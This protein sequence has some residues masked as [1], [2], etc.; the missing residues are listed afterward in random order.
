MEGQLATRG[1]TVLALIALLAA[2]APA[3]AADEGFA[4]SDFPP[5]SLDQEPAA[6][7]APKEAPAKPWRTFELITG[8]TYTSVTSTLTVGRGGGGA[9]LAIDAEGV[10]G[11]NREMWSPEIWTAYRF[12]ERHRIC[13]GF[14]DMTRTSTRALER[15]ITVDGVT[16]NV[17]TSVHS[18][19]GIQFYNLT[20]AWSFLQD[21]RMEMALTLGFDT[22]RAHFSVDASGSQVSAN[23]RFIFPIPL[24]G[25]NAD[26][27]LI[28]DL[29]LRERLQFMYVPVQN[30]AGLVMNFNVALEYSILKNVALGLGFESLRAELEKHASGD[31]LGNFEGDFRFNTAGVLIYIN[32]HL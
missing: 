26:F 20:Y 4:P 13:F 3:F 18:V 10:L 28:P 16:Y 29:W 12:A 23:E 5:M 24:P 11:L 7:A 31:S 2:S 8:V 17:G 6:P 27:E 32:F 30:Y 19:Y 21:A 25:V 15:D 14:D 1:R 9:S 22:L